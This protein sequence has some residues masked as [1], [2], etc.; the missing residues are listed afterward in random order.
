MA[1]PPSSS[2]AA[3]RGALPPA[4]GERRGPGALPEA[5]SPERVRP[6]GAGAGP[7]RVGAAG[8]AR[9]RQR[10]SARLGPAASPPLRVLRC[11]HTGPDRPGRPRTPGTSSSDSPGRGT[12]SSSRAL[13]PPGL[14]TAAPGSAGS[15]CGGCGPWS[16]GRGLLG[17]G[18]GQRSPCCFRGSAPA[19]AG[20]VEL[21]LSAPSCREG[22]S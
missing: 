19:G 20:K 13:V 21:V 12:G 1:V 7:A 6:G 22:C 5:A 10:S 9:R 11:L 8:A 2:A 17:T 15:T 18:A 14:G 16:G 4:M 3:P